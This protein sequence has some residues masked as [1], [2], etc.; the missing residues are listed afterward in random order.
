MPLSAAERRFIWKLKGYNCPY[1]QKQRYA[2]AGVIPTFAEVLYSHSAQTA[3]LLRRRFTDFRIRIGAIPVFLPFT[4]TVATAVPAM[5]RTH[6]PTLTGISTPTAVSIPTMPE[7]CRRCSEI[8]D[9][10]IF[11]SYRPF[12]RKRYYRARGNHS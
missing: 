8:T 4:F 10:R 7:I 3:C 2:A 5:R 9:M 12:F 6:L 11:R 1:R